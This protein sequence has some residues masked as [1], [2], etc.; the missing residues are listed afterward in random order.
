[1]ALNIRKAYIPQIITTVICHRYSL[2]AS[3]TLIAVALGAHH[4]I[5]YAEDV[6]EV[7]PV[8]AC[9]IARDVNLTD[10]IRSHF[11]ECLGWESPLISPAPVCRGS[12]QPINITPLSDPEEI[13]ITA[14]NVS[15]SN[16]GR[17]D[18]TGG[19]EVQQG[20][21]VVN[22]QTAYVYR[23]ASSHKISKI[24]LLGE[25]R[26]LEPDRLMIA[27]KATIYPDSKAGSVEDVLYRFNTQRV[28]AI[29][30]A[31]GRA[32]LIERF[33]NQ[34]YVLKKATYSNCAPQDKA[35][36]IEAD[37]ITLDNA[38]ATGVARNARLRIYDVPVLYSPYLSFPTSKE[39][40]S[41]FLMPTVGMSNIGGFDYAQPYY[42][43]I[44]PNYDATFIPHLYSRRGLMVGGQF[45]YLTL[46]SS[47]VF[48]GRFLP[49]DRA[50]RDFILDNEALYPVLRGISSDRWSVQML[51]STW[52]APNLHLGVNFQQVSDNYFLEDFSSNFAVL[53][54]RQLL[55][56]ADLSYTTDHWLVRGM[57]QSYQTLHPINQTPIDDVYQRLPQLLAAGNYDDLPFNS[58]LSILG[59]FDYFQW[60]DEPFLKSLRAI[61][62]PTLKKPEGPRFHFNP[63]LE[64]PQRKPWGF[65]NPSVEVV[66]NYYNIS[67][68]NFASLN[69]SNPLHSY[70]FPVSTLE[71]GEFN[72]FIPRYSLDGGLYFERS[73]DFLG[74]GLTQT[75]EPRL[76]YL[77]VPYHDQTTIPVFDSGYMI[78]NYDELFFKNRFSGFDRIGDSNQLSYAL[79]SRWLSDENGVERANIS[80]GQIRYFSGRRV[81]LCQNPA[82]TCRDNPLTLGYLSPEATYSPIASRGIYHFNRNWMLTGDYVW[83]PHFRNT[84]NGHLNLHYQP[85][86]N[87]IVNFGYSYLLNGDITQVANS[88]VQVSP[89]HQV[90]LSYAWPFNER[91][92]TLG[93]YNYNISKGYQMMSFL[94]V[95][96]DS[97]CWAVRLLGGRSF[98]SLN[99]LAQ[100][101]YNNNV[102]L[103]ILLKGLGSVGNSDPA[104]TIRS[105]LPTYLDQFHN[106]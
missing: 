14:G 57:L 15:F 77:Y 71:N 105:Y 19:V 99:S 102:Y 29:L 16:S 100:P 47:G 12:Y 86:L 33:P 69:D 35:W 76:F 74:Q 41:G 55:R 53:T 8:Q 80:V 11:A 85:A 54:E 44:A 37:S 81:Q 42:W 94:G 46:N 25:V 103:Q 23:D 98:Q 88:G 95:Q 39:R 7:E 38:K 22:A 72:R 91:W 64:L 66:E 17:S 1:M 58:N 79:S 5:A 3:L 75:L 20:L 68:N 32:S 61:D 84:N 45:R 49:H 51:N 4:A 34:D 40:K 96:Y 43:N 70:G 63:V 73:T 18:L 104:S 56:Q 90:T 28:S 78:F 87:H 65:F 6:L 52:L 60:P 48:N 13:Q 36:Q 50:Y 62:P 89:L 10:A 2:V 97:C 83:D 82:G 101:V 59:Q 24:E 21:R 9:V 67:R 93:G 26:Y 106:S 30:P 92:S 31:W 27:R